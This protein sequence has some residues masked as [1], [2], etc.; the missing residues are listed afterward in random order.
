MAVSPTGLLLLVSNL[1]QISVAFGI[2]S[3]IFGLVI[4]WKPNIISYLIAI[5]LILTG[6]L[7]VLGGIL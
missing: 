6:I 4:L 1:S 5:Y 7:A 3:I 2:F